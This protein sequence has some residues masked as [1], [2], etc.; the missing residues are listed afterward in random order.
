MQIAEL[1]VS[2]PIFRRVLIADLI[3]IWNIQCAMEQL[4]NYRR[5]PFCKC[6]KFLWDMCSVSLHTKSHPTR[7]SSPIK[8]FF[9]Q[10]SSHLRLPNTSAVEDV[11]KLVKTAENRNSSWSTKRGS[12]KPRRKSCVKRRDR[13]LPNES[14]CRDVFLFLVVAL[15]IF[16]SHFHFDWPQSVQNRHHVQTLYYHDCGK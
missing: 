15:I 11:W 3:W 16:F 6:G 4:F 5:P 1:S 14:E 13:D 9:N 8:Q 2:Q 7:A 10:Q 12:R